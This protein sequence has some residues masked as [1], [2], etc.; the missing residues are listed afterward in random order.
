MH[1]TMHDRSMLEDVLRNCLWVA[2]GWLLRSS[3]MFSGSSLRTCA[4]GPESPISTFK[5]ERLVPGNF[6]SV[7]FF[8]VWPCL[9]VFGVG[10]KFS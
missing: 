6:A 8:C 5:E 2:L 1:R 3:K 10:T 7:C 4:M 9:D